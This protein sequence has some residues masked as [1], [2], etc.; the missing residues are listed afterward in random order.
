MSKSINAPELPEAILMDDTEAI[1][2]SSG[3]DNN[4]LTLAQPTTTTL[5]PTLIQPVYQFRALKHGCYFLQWK[6]KDSYWYRFNGTMRIERHNQGV[7]ASG[8][9][10]YHQAFRFTSWPSFRVIPNPDPSPSAGIPIFRRSSYRYYL[11]VTQILEWFTVSNSFTMKFDRR[12]FDS[13]NNTWSSDGVFTAKMTFKTPPAVYPSGAVYLE[14]TVTDSSGVDAGTISM[15]WVS[16]YLRKATL[17]VDRVSQSEYPVNNG[18]SIDW[19]DVYDAVGWD[20]NVYESDTNLTEPSGQSWSDAEMHQAMLTRRD[21]SNLDTEWR[22]HLIC[23]RRLD[24]T[25]RGI[26]YDAYGSD[27]NNIPREGAGISSHWI[28]PNESQWGTVKGQRFGAADAPYFRTAV[29]EIG[30]AMGLYHNTADNGFMNTTGVI[31]SSSGTFP[32]NIQWSF[33]AAD[34]KRLRHMPDPW[35]RPGMIPF[36]QS[37][38]SAPI[39]PNDMMDVGEALMLN[40]ETLLDATPIGAPVR[41][42]VALTNISD[43]PLD[44]PA[45]L[46]LKSEYV[47]GRVIDPSGTSRSFRSVMRC[48]EEHEHQVLKPNTSMTSDIT[49]LR[50]AEGALFPSP[51]LH[52]IEVNV[53]W[54]M[55]G[56]PVRV[57][58]KVSVMVTPPVNN[59]HAKAAISTLMAPDLLLTLVFGGDHLDEGVEALNAALEDKTLAPH[60]AVIQAKRLGRRFSQRQADPKAA[61]KAITEDT[62]MTP[63]EVRKIALIA[64]ELGAGDLKKIGTKVMATMKKSAAGEKSVESLLKK[65]DS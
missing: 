40:L 12:S 41:I 49:L 35:V 44:A 9:L 64:K 62:I 45:S 57:S 11:R 36:G 23:V 7:T 18:G 16:N 53:A 51:G 37:Y 20:V 1:V 31:A 32:G 58:S 38:G 26:M 50:G 25:S 59:S 34:S 27:S 14:G 33:N 24:S 30:H 43:T 2:G 3:A 48:I 8:D 21:S 19:K 63:S 52:Q 5:S 56:M 28:I 22:Y 39:S 10:Y 6:P 42:R 13:S 47:S 54:D 15:G 4:T 65:L 61:M 29:H 60:F 46:S 55:N 17:E